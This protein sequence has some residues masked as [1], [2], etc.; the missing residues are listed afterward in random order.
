MILCTLNCL[1]NKS[2]TFKKPNFCV[3][4]LFSPQYKFKHN[5]TKSSY[6]YTCNGIQIADNNQCIIYSITRMNE[7]IQKKLDW[8]AVI[9]THYVMYMQPVILLCLYQVIIRQKMN[10]IKYLS[11]NF[12]WHC[13]VVTVSDWKAL[14]SG[15]ESR[16]KI[17]SIQLLFRKINF[18]GS[19]SNSS[20]F[21]AK[22]A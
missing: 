17:N 5:L 4:L 19:K 14:G 18:F 22:L 13:L 10:H 1:R 7:M 3:L 2:V 20:K 15:F 11:M 6:F 16:F 9:N 21:Q 8:N 12:Q